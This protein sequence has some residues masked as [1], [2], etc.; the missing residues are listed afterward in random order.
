MGNDVGSNLRQPR[1]A[2]PVKSVLLVLGVLVDEKTFVAVNREAG[3][4]PQHLRGLSPGLLD[5]PQLRI[6]G[7][8]PSTGQLHIRQA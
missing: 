7:R 5:L 1:L 4:D 6:G 8:E 3:V 2:H